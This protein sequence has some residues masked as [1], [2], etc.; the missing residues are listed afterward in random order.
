MTRQLLFICIVL[1]TEVFNCFSHAVAEDSRIEEIT[2]NLI[3]VFQEGS[4]IP[5]LARR[6]ER[7]QKKAEAEKNAEIAYQRQ[8]KEIFEDHFRYK[9]ILREY[10]NNTQKLR[11]MNIRKESRVLELDVFDRYKKAN[12]NLLEVFRKN[13]NDLLKL[14]EEAL[15]PINFIQE[16]VFLLGKQGHHNPSE[17]YKKITLKI[18]EQI[19]NRYMTLLKSQGENG[20]QPDNLKAFYGSLNVNSVDI[21]LLVSKKDAFPVCGE[22]NNKGILYLVSNLYAVERVKQVRIQ[23]ADPRFKAEN[24]IDIQNWTLSQ[25][26]SLCDPDDQTKFDDF[27]EAVSEQIR[28]VETRNGDRNE[29]D[30]FWQQQRK[31][32]ADIQDKRQKIDK[33]EKIIRRIK[34]EAG[35]LYSDIQKSD[36]S[37]SG[38]KNSLSRLQPQKDEF[39]RNFLTQIS[40][41]TIE[42]VGEGISD[43][44]ESTVDYLLGTGRDLATDQFVQSIIDLTKMEEAETEGIRSAIRPEL[45]DAE[46]LG[47]TQLSG[48]K[49]YLLA[50][51]KYKVDISTDMIPFGGG[52]NLMVKI[53]SDQGTI[54]TDSI[55]KEEWWLVAD[56]KKN[57][58][59][60]GISLEK[61]QK[62]LSQ[63]GGGWEFPSKDQLDYIRNMGDGAIEG[64]NSDRAYWTGDSHSS[65]K[66]PMGY[67]FGVN[68]SCKEIYDEYHPNRAL[69]ILLLRPYQERKNKEDNI[70]KHYQEYE[71]AEIEITPV[72][73]ETV[74]YDTEEG[75]Q[76]SPSIPIG[77]YIDKVGEYHIE[78]TVNPDEW[79]KQ[80]DG[81]W[82]GGKLVT[83]KFKGNRRKIKW[84]YF[85]I[86]KNPHCKREWFEVSRNSKNAPKKFP[87]LLEVYGIP[88]HANTTK[89]IL[90]KFIDVKRG[91]ACSCFFP[92][93]SKDFSI[94]EKHP[95]R[96]VYNLDENGEL[97]IKLYFSENSFTLPNNDN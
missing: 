14:Q 88:V 50:K 24:I 83:F 81:T 30:K 10:Q 1:A 32:G 19:R 54:F 8:L 3:K 34:G 41:R 53:S 51:L 78:G 86:R 49:F 67:C 74:K 62:Y 21:R 17:I 40:D 45:V 89:L 75:A 22:S 58:K 47:W 97:S 46:P 43:E 82:V 11:L 36:N 52:S 13:E 39:R 96:I 38:I 70:L 29:W 95:S 63:N 93:E 85:Q 68:A 59:R 9:R 66:L 56:Q 84:K 48:A 37:A 26:Y 92:F 87:L 44:T 69:R 65:S 73:D 94:Y 6:D 57:I 60:H 25:G 16:C 42:V 28:D 20:E 76:D 12:E 23:K 71:E 72:K 27:K 35:M 15:T 33:I 31:I 55:R 2:E 7:D 18:E 80:E 90:N 64:V 91:P 79:K 4:E 5:N 77:I 61:A